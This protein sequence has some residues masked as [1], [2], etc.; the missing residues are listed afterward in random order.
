LCAKFLKSDDKTRK[1]NI[2][3]RASVASF[4]WV[5]RGYAHTLR[6]VLRHQPLVLGITG[7]TVCLAVYLYIVVP[8][9]FFPQ[10]DSGALNGN[11]VASQDV[12]F[13]TMRQKLNQYISI[14]MADP[15]VAVV[16]GNVGRANT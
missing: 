13:Q 4:D 14:I 8:K 16:S 2:F 3:Y 15:A 1:H 7:A 9:G 10:Q 11:A 5:Y 12:S 6:W